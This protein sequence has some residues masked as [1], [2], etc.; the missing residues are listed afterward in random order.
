MVPP[1]AQHTNTSFHGMKE[2]VLKDIPK[3][4]IKS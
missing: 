1:K 2:L 3:K 4:K